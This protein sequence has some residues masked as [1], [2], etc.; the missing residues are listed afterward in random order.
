MSLI[1]IHLYYYQFFQIFLRSTKSWS[2][3]PYLDFTAVSRSW[4]F[5]FVR[6]LFFRALSSAAVSADQRVVIVPKYFISNII[7]ASLFE[8]LIEQNATLK[9]LF[10][11]F[12]CCCAGCCGTLR[13]SSWNTQI[14]IWESWPSKIL[15]IF[16][17]H[18]LTITF[19]PHQ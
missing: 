18:L 7:F 10:S 12:L 3:K 2:M 1:T 17:I 15:S 19:I 5:L 11:T 14:R 8:I 13:R 6:A 16:V 9:G 4:R